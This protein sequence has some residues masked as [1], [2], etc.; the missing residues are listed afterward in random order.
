MLLEI[1]FAFIRRSIFETAMILLSFL[2]SELV[3]AAFSS[4][5]SIK[6]CCVSEFSLPQ[7]SLDIRFLSSNKLKYIDKI[8]CNFSILE[9]RSLQS[10]KNSSS[11]P[12]M[13]VAICLSSSFSV[14]LMSSVALVSL[15]ESSLSFSSSTL[16]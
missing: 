7:I 15:L 10:L 14:S 4:F 12:F 13:T 9:L 1:S 6:I 3:L 8:S 5:I 2:D 11:N 16:T